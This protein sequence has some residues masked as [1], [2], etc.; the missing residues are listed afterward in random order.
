MFKA[1]FWLLISNDTVSES[2]VS[3][4]FTVYCVDVSGYMLILLACEFRL[5]MRSPEV[6]I[7]VSVG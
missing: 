6:N 1:E 7:G 5:E 4:K 3:V 2:L